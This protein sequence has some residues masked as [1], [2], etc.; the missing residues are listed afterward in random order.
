MARIATTI[1]DSYTKE[2]Q[3]LGEKQRAEYDKKSIIL[4]AECLE[5]LVNYA[6]TKGLEE[7]E[8][9]T[10]EEAIRENI[11]IESFYASPDDPQKVVS[12]ARTKICKVAKILFDNPNN[13]NSNATTIYDFINQNSGT[14]PIKIEMD[15]L[16]KY[17]RFVVKYENVGRQDVELQ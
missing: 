7:D 15:E 4:H 1:K 16:M 14:S 3:E 9:V 13:E 2:Y 12:I 11:A 10:I 6:T 5:S 17:M 8:L